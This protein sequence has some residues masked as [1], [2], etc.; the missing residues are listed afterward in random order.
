[1]SVRS[2]KGPKRD[3]DFDLSLSRTL[4]EELASVH[5]IVA[6]LTLQ[7]GD[8]PGNSTRGAFHVLRAA[9]RRDPIAAY[10]LGNYL[11]ES[12][13]EGR[14]RPRRRVTSLRLFERAAVE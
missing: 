11:A 8:R 14:P 7:R 2:G 12:V 13:V 9:A 10:N 5:G 3:R 4:E 1:M 6:M